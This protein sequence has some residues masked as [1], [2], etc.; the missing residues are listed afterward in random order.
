[1]VSR[2]RRA[3]TA[4]LAALQVSADWGR[5]WEDVWFTQSNF[6]NADGFTP[7]SVDVS[8]YAGQPIQFRFVFYLGGGSVEYGADSARGWHFD[9]IAFSGMSEL[10]GVTRSLVNS[11]EFQFPAAEAGDHYVQIR[12]RSGD[13]FLR[14]ADPTIVQVS[15]AAGGYSAWV[16]RQELQAGLGS[17][18]LAVSGADYDGDGL[19]QLIEYALEATGFNPAHPDSQLLPGAEIEG[20]DLCLHYTVDTSLTDVSVAVEVSAD[21]DNWF[22]PG[23]PGAPGGFVDQADGAPSGPLQGRVASV[24]YSGFER[25]FM[26]LRVDEL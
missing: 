22:L 8:E 12:A 19:P 11:S 21:L 9:D 6:S 4:Q 18:A 16:S 15:A 25:L 17:G 23:Q 5:G 14:Y 7:V 24:P 26:R 1:F 10:V 2:L 13:T 3:G 20:G